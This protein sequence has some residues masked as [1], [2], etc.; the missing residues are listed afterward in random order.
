M[1]D[2]LSEQQR[3]EER[4]EKL[5]KVSLSRTRHAPTLIVPNVLALIVAPAVP[6][7]EGGVGAAINHNHDE[8][9]D[10]E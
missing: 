10:H 9:Y 1:R 8:K 2:R 5:G 6:T 3:R 7:G 4:I